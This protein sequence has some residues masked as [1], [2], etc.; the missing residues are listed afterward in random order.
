MKNILISFLLIGS[1]YTANSQKLIA[2]VQPNSTP[3]WTY[4]DIEGKQLVDAVFKTGYP[5]TKEGVALIQRELAPH[6]GIINSS[7]NILS[8][9]NDR[10]SLTARGSY[11][12]YYDFSDGLLPVKIK[13]KFGFMDING[14]LVIP[15]RLDEVTIFSDGK[16]V[17][18]NGTTFMLI[19][20]DKSVTSLNIP[21]LKEVKKYSEGLAPFYLKGPGCGYLD[22]EG[23][24]AIEPKFKSVG[25]FHGGVAWAKLPNNKVGFIN[26]Q[27]EWIVEPQFS[28]ADDFDPESGL[29]RV[30]KDLVWGYVNMEGEF[31]ELEKT[32][33]YKNYHEGLCI[34]RKNGKFGFLNPEGE[35]AIPNQYQ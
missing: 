21:K 24:I 32:N 28:F 30:K 7:G 22:K 16:A 11:A 23:K 5:F 26:K 19:D 4:I 9:E 27:G 8:F 12:G 29:A 17:A 18:K 33:I 31:M 13:G 6:F 25:Y 35:W 10:F 34:G 15:A 20:K 14:K 2:L 3:G 1:F